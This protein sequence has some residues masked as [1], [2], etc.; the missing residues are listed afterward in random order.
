MRGEW[1]KRSF[2]IF[3]MV[4][5][6]GLFEIDI[7]FKKREYFKKYQSLIQDKLRLEVDWRK[8]QIDLSEISSG[9][10]LEKDAE[11]KAEMTI[12]DPSLAKI[13]ILNE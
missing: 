5:F 9:L 7:H 8:I 11:I 13:V 6:S 1:Y 4:F 10:S 12:L 2:L 3:I